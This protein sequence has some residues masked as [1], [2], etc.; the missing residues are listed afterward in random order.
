MVVYSFCPSRFIEN[1]SDSYQG[2]RKENKRKKPKQKPF[3]LGAFVVIVGRG[4]NMTN[5]SNKVF[6]KLGRDT[7]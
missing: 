7:Y 1:Q 2:S 5:K 6:N 4:A 3:P